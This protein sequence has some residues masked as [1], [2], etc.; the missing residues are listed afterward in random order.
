MGVMPVGKIMT[1]CSWC[2]AWDSGIGC[3]Y[4][5]GETVKALGIRK[6]MRY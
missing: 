6:C 3:G 4:E 1:G 5:V 2:E